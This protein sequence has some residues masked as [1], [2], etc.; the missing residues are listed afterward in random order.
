MTPIFLEVSTE[1]GGGVHLKMGGVHLKMGDKLNLRTFLYCTQSSFSGFLVA[2]SG[3]TTNR[4]RR[5][6]EDHSI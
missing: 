3:L 2:F 6:S 4:I 5:Y 1:N